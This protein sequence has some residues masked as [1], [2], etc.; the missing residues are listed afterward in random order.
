MGGAVRPVVHHGELRVVE[1]NVGRDEAAARTLLARSRRMLLTPL[2]VTATITCTR[3]EEQ[4]LVRAEPR[5]EPMLARWRDHVG[6]VSLCLH[7]PLALLALAGEPGIEVERRALSIGRNGVM[8]SR[9]NEHDVVIGA[10][11]RAIVTRVLA[12]LG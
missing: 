4:A 10:D 9:G 7:D 6:D 5:L 8:R 2:D 12:L 11:R 3:E 1:H